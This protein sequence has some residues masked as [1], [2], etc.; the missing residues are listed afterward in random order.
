MQ[1]PRK[2]TSPVKSAWV[3]LQ[4]SPQIQT[5]VSSD[6]E[7][8]ASLQADVEGGLAEYALR[9]F[10]RVERTIGEVRKALDRLPS[11]LSPEA[12]SYTHLTL[13]TI[14]SV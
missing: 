8:I 12:V 14:C 5:Q 4:G 10:D 6:G 13:P 1:A 2:L 3:E 9:H 7:T 11:K